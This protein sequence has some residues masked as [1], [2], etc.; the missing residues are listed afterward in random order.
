MAVILFGY[1]DFLGYIAYSTQVPD[2][3]YV[4]VTTG[5]LYRDFDWH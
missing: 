2:G 4:A 5:L 1:S 3:A